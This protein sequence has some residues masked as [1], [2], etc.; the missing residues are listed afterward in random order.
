MG[1]SLMHGEIRKNIASENSNLDKHK[2]FYMGK[3]TEPFVIDQKDGLYQ[4]LYKHD[5]RYK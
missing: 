5:E 4:V 2:A 1:L 3:N